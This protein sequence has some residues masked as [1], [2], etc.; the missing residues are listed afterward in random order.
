MLLEQLL[1]T[2]KITFSLHRKQKQAD[3]SEFWFTH[4]YLVCVIYHLTFI[5]C[6]C[7]YFVCS[8]MHMQAY[9]HKNASIH[10]VRCI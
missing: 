8:Q 5:Y 2:Q 10:A 9:M 3:L 6:V 1:H 4:K 7:G